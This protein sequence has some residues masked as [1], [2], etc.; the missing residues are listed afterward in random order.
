MTHEVDT[1]H[2]EVRVPPLTPISQA[3][4]SK[5]GP[6]DTCP[7]HPQGVLY[8]KSSS[9]T[10]PGQDLPGNTSSG[11]RTV[12]QLVREQFLTFW[13]KP[14]LLV[15]AQRENE[16]MDVVT[17]VDLERQSTAQPHP[18]VQFVPREETHCKL[19][20]VSWCLNTEPD[21]VL[22]FEDL[23]VFHSQE[24]CVTLDPVQQPTSEKE[25]D[26]VGEMMLLVDD[27]NDEGEQLQKKSVEKDEKS[28]RCD[29]V[30][31]SVVSE[32]L[33]NFHGEEK[34][35]TSLPKKRKLRNLLD[36]VENDIPL[37]ELPKCVNINIT[38]L[39]PNLRTRKWYTCSLCKKQFDKSSYLISH[40]RI[41][42][43]VKPYDCSHCGK[44]FSHKTNLS[45]HERIH[46]EEEVHASSQYKKKKRQQAHSS[47]CEGAYVKEK[48]EYRRNNPSVEL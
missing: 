10:K 8:T 23:H 45:K 27:S 18:L 2:G 6:L 28:A 11:P 46:T 19:D 26:L 48:L 25:E 31:G 38:A 47:H 15:P 9:N 24:E 3:S 20:D 32:K 22:V 12:Q 14:N 33:G 39:T 40:Q 17:A 7:P 4:V 29:E 1:L 44:S 5:P 16:T 42:T 37:E 41:H 13:P 30:D 21:Q 36:A 43:G 34:Q 35:N